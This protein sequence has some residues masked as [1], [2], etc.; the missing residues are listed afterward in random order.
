MSS[1]TWIVLGALCGGLG[2]GLGAFGAHGLKDRVT[3]DLL[4]TFEVAVRYQMY[5]A[6]G[7]IAAGLLGELG[8]GK[9][10]TATAGAAFLGGILVFCGLLY[11]YVLLG[12][13]YRFLGAIVPLGGVAFI[14]G[15]LALAVAAWPR[16]TE[17][18]ERSG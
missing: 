16:R 2:V 1:R 17:A 8:A 3:P 10:A 14:V 15:W 5:H 13:S 12:P 11:A 7:L 9:G 6:L 18:A 4:A